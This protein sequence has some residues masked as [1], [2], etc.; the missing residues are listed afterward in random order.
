MVGIFKVGKFEKIKT[1]CRL[2]VC[3]ENIYL[4]FQNSHASI[5]PRILINWK[6]QISIFDGRTF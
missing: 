6:P 5:F 1:T 2:V 4:Q 3:C